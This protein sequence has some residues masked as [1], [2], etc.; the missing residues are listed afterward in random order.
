MYFTPSLNNVNLSH[1]F[2]SLNVRG[3]LTAKNKLIAS[4][5]EVNDIDCSTLS[6]DR[7]NNILVP[8]HYLTNQ[9]IKL[10]VNGLSLEEQA[11]DFIAFRDLITQMFELPQ[12]YNTLLFD[13][14]MLYPISQ[15]PTG[16]LTLVNKPDPFQRVRMMELGQSIMNNCLIIG[17]NVGVN[18]ARYS[19][20][21]ANIIGAFPSWSVDII[22]TL[23][24]VSLNT[25]VNVCA[26]NIETDSQ[27]INDL[28]SLITSPVFYSTISTRSVILARDNL[29]KIVPNKHILSPLSLVFTDESGYLKTPI[30]IPH[31]PF[32]DLDPALKIQT[33]LVNLV[34][35]FSSY[36]T[37]DEINI[38]IS[39]FA[40]IASYAPL[41]AAL[42]A[43]QVECNAILSAVILDKAGTTAD[44]A[45]TTADLVGTTANKITCQG[46]LVEMNASITAGETSIG[47]KVSAGEASIGAQVSAGETSLAASTTAGEV[48][49]GVAEGG[50]LTSIGA[51]EAA[52]ITA[53]IAAGLFHL[54]GPKGDRGDN[55]DKGD[56]G[57]TGIGFINMNDHYDILLPLI[58]TSRIYS[59]NVP[60]VSGDM[61]NKLYLDTTYSTTTQNNELYKAIGYS[62]DLT[63]YSTTVQNNALYKAIGYSPDLSSYSTTVQNNELYKAIGYSPDLSSYS[64]TVQN[65]ALYKAIGY[66]PDLSSYS[67]TVQNNALYKAIDYSPDL[68]SYSTTDQTNTLIQSYNYITNNINGELYLNNGLYNTTQGSLR[69]VSTGIGNFI[70][71]GLQ[72]YDTANSSTSADLIFCNMSWGT[73]WMRIKADGKIGISTNAPDEKLHVNGNIKADSN[74]ICSSVPTSDSHLTNKLYIANNYLPLSGGTL[75]GTLNTGSEVYVNNSVDACIRLLTNTGGNYIQSGLNN[76]T[77]IKNLYI[78]SING[79]TEWIRCDG[80]DGN[81]GIGNIDPT[82]RLH[83]NGNFLASGNIN[84]VSPTIMSYL[85][86][87]TSDVQTQLGNKLNTSVISDYTLTSGLTT[88]INDVPKWGDYTLTSGLT[89]YINGVSKWGDKLSLSGGSLTGALHTSDVMSFTDH[90]ET[91]KFYIYSSGSS[92]YIKSYTNL[93][94]YAINIPV[95]TPLTIASNGNIT[96]S[97]NINEVSPTK[98]SY[99][100]TVTSNVQTQLDNLSSSIA[101]IKQKTNKAASFIYSFDNGSYIVLTGSGNYEI[102]LPDPVNATIF[103]ITFIK[104]HNSLYAKVITFYT[105]YG[106]QNVMNTN[107]VTG[108]TGSDSMDIGANRRIV[109]VFTDG[110]KWYAD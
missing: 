103:E 20:I 3:N 69:L 94:N 107:C 19:D 15:I 35:T 26:T 13:P 12:Q 16:L 73:E 25:K 57:N 68:S 11:T 96:T 29:N 2:N 4:F 43:I 66:S 84:G 50:A 109:K 30:E 86:T 40:S 90:M 77:S 62:P 95:N 61:V 47:A 64:T 104:Q 89:A 9:N 53:I 106:G 18:P 49:I 31:F 110:V 6:S 1:L 60:T 10:L 65:N 21:I 14:I 48:S 5:A 55:G 36:Y 46:T 81:V 93:K 102:T 63:S 34:N 32:I 33:R 59:T 83:V 97:G 100:T 38:M 27:T 23:F 52:A 71:S 98:M 28:S 108:S 101:S 39:V 80:T 37:K 79:G 92:F 44:L 75:T 56:Q 41:M 85:T 24:P 17:G 72:H 76:G 22:N 67:T 78:T 82:E 99:L 51:A 45:G 42:T 58:T 54:K 7:V 70:Q 87:L 105:N 8:S 74:M 88:Y 91:A